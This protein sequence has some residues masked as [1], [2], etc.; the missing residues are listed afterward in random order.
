ML[1]KS[2]PEHVR[3]LAAASVQSAW[4]GHT[5]RRDDQHHKLM[6]STLRDYD[7]A[8]YEKIEPTP[9]PPKSRFYR[10]VDP[11]VCSACQYHNQAGH[12]CQACGSSAWLSLTVPNPTTSTLMKTAAN[13]VVYFKPGDLPLLGRLQALGR[14][15][16]QRTRTR[17]RN[18]ATV[19]AY[20]WRDYVVRRTLVCLFAH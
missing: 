3:A 11:W 1:R 8:L 6:E 14:G 13:S 10:S 2:D 19:M 9:S 12:C 16:V 20:A 17:R 15:F 4:R 5:V 18:A 7:K